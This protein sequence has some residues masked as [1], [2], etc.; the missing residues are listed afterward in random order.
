MPELPW[1]AKGGSHLSFVCLSSPPPQGD[2]GI[3]TSLLACLICP[4]INWGGGRK[5]EL[6]G[7]PTGAE[8]GVSCGCGGPYGSGGA[9]TGFYEARSGLYGRSIGPGVA[10]GK[11]GKL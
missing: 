11:G 10:C 4:V 6:E 1:R 8:S 3:Q 9:L 7:A 2:P 5:G